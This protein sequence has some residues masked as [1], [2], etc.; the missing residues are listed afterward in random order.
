MA[1]TFQLHKDAGGKFRFTLKSMS[2]ELI[3]SS[4]TY[5]SKEAALDAI[6][7]VRNNAPTAK[8]ED[9]TSSGR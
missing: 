4:E 8:V 1:G 5:H 6:R 9:M 3:V 7:S 2:G